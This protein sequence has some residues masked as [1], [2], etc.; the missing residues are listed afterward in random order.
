MTAHNALMGVL[1]YKMKQKEK[2]RAFCQEKCPI[3]F[4]NNK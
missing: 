3:H 2:N 1:R 4:Y